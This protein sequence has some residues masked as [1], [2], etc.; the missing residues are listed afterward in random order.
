MGEKTVNW[1]VYTCFIGLIPMLAR[2]F[3]WCVS[4]SG[5]EIIAVSDLVAFGL[6]L[7]TSNIHEVNSG[8]SL[9]SR[10][11]SVHNGISSLF[12]TFYSLVL[13]ATI[14]NVP[15]VDYSGLKRSAIILSIVSFFISLSIFYERSAGGRGSSDPASTHA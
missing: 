8:A 13:F 7:H 11:K 5:V 3:V 4:Q 10:W 9:D 2:L 14:L 1:L 6:V 12:L 15:S